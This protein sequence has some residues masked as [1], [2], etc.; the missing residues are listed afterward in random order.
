MENK[1]KTP[2]T[3]Q[4]PP[5]IPPTPKPEDAVNSKL[6]EL[7]QKHQIL[8]DN[9]KTIQKAV[10]K[11]EEENRRLK[12]QLEEREADR[13]LLRSFAATLAEQKGKTEEEYLEDVQKRQPDLL[14][15][16]DILEAKRKQDKLV[17][18]AQEKAEEFRQ[19]TE[20]LGL[21]DKD[22]EY[23][24]IHDLVV[25]GKFE[26]ANVRLGKLEAKKKEPQLPPKS[27]ADKQKEIEE[28]ARKMLEE[29]GLLKSDTNL[30]SG[31]GGKTTY[32]RKAIAEMPIAEYEKVKDDITLARREGRIKD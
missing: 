4:T 5:A 12:E 28:A 26:R 13:N 2:E 16:Y 3:I 20:A 23:W 14:K 30:P 21:T 24:E 29:K 22:E 1:E 25:D 17:R 19:K 15:Q 27:E 9:Y 32:S 10:S 11:R 6:Q 31:A 18:E 8:E 7:G